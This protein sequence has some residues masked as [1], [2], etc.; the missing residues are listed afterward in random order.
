MAEAVTDAPTW[1]P[2]GQTVLVMAVANL[3]LLVLFLGEQLM[4]A[5]AATQ[6]A[7]NPKAGDW[8]ILFGVLVVFSLAGL[9]APRRRLAI[10]L[11]PV[12]ALALPLMTWFLRLPP[13]H[14]AGLSTPTAALLFGIAAIVATGAA[15]AIATARSMTFVAPAHVHE[16][17]RP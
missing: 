7:P 13:R 6:P 5:T 12:A 8:A 10:G 2:R 15:V 17:D 14:D 11:A 3:L 1:G 4:L 16:T 9:C